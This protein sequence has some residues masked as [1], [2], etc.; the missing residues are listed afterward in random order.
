MAAEIRYG[1]IPEAEKEL[2]TKVKKLKKLQTSRRVL[3][4]EITEEDIATVVSKWTGVPLNRM[5]ESEAHKLVRM[6]EELEKRIIGQAE[7]RNY[8][9]AYALD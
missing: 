3:K 8:H 9:Y 7:A 6:E 4:E 1:K 5:L 2:D